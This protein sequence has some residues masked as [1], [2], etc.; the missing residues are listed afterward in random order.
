[1]RQ[2]MQ[3]SPYL[4]GTQRSLS[5]CNWF[6]FLAESWPSLS[7]DWLWPDRGRGAAAKDGAA[8]MHT[9]AV[10]AQAFRLA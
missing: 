5:T 9:G 7:S 4:L 3:S 10:F 8:E 6:C 2:L 1:M